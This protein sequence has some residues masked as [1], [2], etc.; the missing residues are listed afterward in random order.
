MVRLDALE[1]LWNY[2]RV[3]AKRA[4]GLFHEVIVHESPAGDPR[5]EGGVSRIVKLL[6]ANGHHIGTLHEV[7]MPDGSTPHSHPKDYTRRD[8]SRVRVSSERA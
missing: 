3:P 2:S 7:V 5:F 1:S 4:D 8:C 6:T